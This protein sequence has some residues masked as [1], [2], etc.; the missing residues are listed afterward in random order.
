MSQPAPAPERAQAKRELSAIEQR[1][2]PQE[3]P[4]IQEVRRHIRDTMWWNAM[5]CQDEAG[6]SRCLENLEEIADKDLPHVSPRSDHDL[7]RVLE[8]QNLWQSAQIVATLSRQRKETRGPHYR[9]DYPEPREAFA[10]SFAVEL[11]E[12]PRPG[13]RI[14]YRTRLVDLTSE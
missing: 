9:T 8:L 6:L 12:S 11:T 1:L 7:F 2:S 14:S 3:G 13:E 10:G 5:I 4:T